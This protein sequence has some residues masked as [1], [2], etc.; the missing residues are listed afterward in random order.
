[1]NNGW[2]KIKN[3]KTSI[4]FRRNIKIKWIMLPKLKVIV[5]LRFMENN[6]FNLYRNDKNIYFI[7][8]KKPIKYDQ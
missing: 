5:I 6:A 2:N 3:M 8:K 1:M 7:F 4:I